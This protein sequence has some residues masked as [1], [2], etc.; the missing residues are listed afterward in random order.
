[1]RSRADLPAHLSI[2]PFR[3]R[4]IDTESLSRERL[5]APDIAHPFHGVNSVENPTTTVDRAHALSIVF[6]DGDVFS[7]RTAALLL[8]AP[9]PHNRDERLHV[10]TM[11]DGDRF[12]RRGVIGHTSKRVPVSVC[13]GLPIVA[14]PI[15]WSQLA[16]VLEHDDLVAVGDF[17]VTPN[18]HRRTPAITSP[19]ALRAAIPTRGRG[20][21][22]ARTALADVRVGAESRRET[23]L[24]LLLMRSG[25]PEPMLNPA[26]EL[27]A[28]TYH[29]D[30][31]YER[32]RLAIEYLGDQ[33]RTDSREWGRDIQRRELFENRGFRVVAI[34]AHD[35]AEPHQLL[36]RVAHAIAQQQR[37]TQRAS[38]TL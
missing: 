16:T 7:H 5:R 34:T 14:P 18:R 27:G 12:R 30:L 4:E 1:M 25:L 11:G 22:R 13:L 32:W 20:S 10:T 31:F 19:T 38:G 24:R 15:A 9:L 33:H 6:R 17:L 35:L 36:A 21:A 26:I 8:G 2:A 28:V 23:L 29:P 37:R 3:T